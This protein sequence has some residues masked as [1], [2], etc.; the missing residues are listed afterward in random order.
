MADYICHISSCMGVSF[1][2]CDT[3]NLRLSL[4][5]FRQGNRFE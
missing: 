3:L 2:F 4:C 5:I 1:L